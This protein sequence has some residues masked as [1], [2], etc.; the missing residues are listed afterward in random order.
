MP[1]AFINASSNASYSADGCHKRCGA[2]K[3]FLTARLACSMALR[4][5]G[6]FYIKRKSKG[7][8]YEQPKLDKTCNAV[9]RRWPRGVLDSRLTQ[10]PVVVVISPSVVR[11]HPKN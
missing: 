7:S 3:I 2:D 11:C 6:K 9:I 5:E 10:L 8:I 1:S 4:N